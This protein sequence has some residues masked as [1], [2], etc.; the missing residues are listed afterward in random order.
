MLKTLRRTAVRRRA[1]S[2]KCWPFTRHGPGP[3]RGGGLPLRSWATST[4]LDTLQTQGDPFEDRASLIRARRRRSLARSSPVCRPPPFWRGRAVRGAPGCWCRAIHAGSRRPYSGRRRAARWSHAR[5]SR[6]ACGPGLR[7]GAR[8]TRGGAVGPAPVASGPFCLCPCGEG[9]RG[10]VGGVVRRVRRTG[11]AVDEPSARLARLADDR[12]AV[13]GFHGLPSLRRVAAPLSHAAPR[14]P[15]RAVAAVQRQPPGHP[16]LARAD[17]I[18]YVT[19]IS[20]I[21][22]YRTHI[23]T[24][25]VLSSRLIVTCL[26]GS[27]RASMRCPATAVGGR[28][29]GDGRRDRA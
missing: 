14:R 3:R 13:C 10:Q 22:T 29:H 28:G 6:R 18:A 21:I 5:R 1:S 19:I 26:E 17:P 11:P 23:V 12:P 2:L 4:T 15:F 24:C 16:M 25:L 20:V 8:L 27:A 9:E 7:A